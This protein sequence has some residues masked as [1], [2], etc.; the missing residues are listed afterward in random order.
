M[1][2]LIEFKSWLQSL[3]NSDMTGELEVSFAGPMTMA[4]IRR[5]EA[6]IECTLPQ[7][8]RD[9]LIETG[10]F[11]STHF[12]DV[13]N[14]IK[15]VDNDTMLNAPTGIIDHIDWHWGGRPELADA[16]TIEQMATLNARYRVFGARCIDD[17]R[18]DYLFFSVDCGF[19]NLLLDQDDIHSGIAWLLD[20][21][22]TA[23]GGRSLAELIDQ[24]L[25]ALKHDIEEG[26]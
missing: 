15:F 21:I 19:Y 3:D 1:K 12:A 23:P 25:S 13:W 8:L 16:L 17:N 14:T 20:S 5:I 26:L 4:E 24:Q 9:A 6:A 11:I 22:S 10:P 18:Y 7:S 2:A